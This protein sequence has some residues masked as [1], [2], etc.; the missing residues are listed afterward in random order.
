MNDEFERSLTRQPFRSPPDNLE[1]TLLAAMRAR[2][3]NSPPAGKFAHLLRQL[4]GWVDA[5]ALAWQTLAALWLVG[6]SANYLCFRSPGPAV[7]ESSRLP[8]EQIAA[9]RAQRAELYALTRSNEPEP[10][11]E[12][13]RRAPAPTRPRS[14]LQSTNPPHLG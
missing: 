11:E 6:L 8:P 10:A 3:Q 12:P 9:A 4:L 14:D 7:L 13:R 1:E 2:R 5:P